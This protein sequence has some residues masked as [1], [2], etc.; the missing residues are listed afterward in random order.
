MT[1]ISSREINQNHTTLFNETD[2]DKRRQASLELFKQYL[3]PNRSETILKR[4]GYSDNLQGYVTGAINYVGLQ[5]RMSNHGLEARPSTDATGTGP[6]SLVESARK[7]L[8]EFTVTLPAN[9]DWHA[10]DALSGDEIAALKDLKSLVR[11]ALIDPDLLGDGSEATLTKI[12][13]TNDRLPRFGIQSTGFFA[14]LAMRAGQAV[15]YDARRL[16]ESDVQIGLQSK[17]V[18][19]Q[20]EVWRELTSMDNRLFVYGRVPQIKT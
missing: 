3:L 14:N 15:V 11:L 19:P 9:V 20:T 2:Q 5:H 10:R 6:A 18:A 1:A 7:G 17:G 16:N 8:A 13:H 12:L 4:L